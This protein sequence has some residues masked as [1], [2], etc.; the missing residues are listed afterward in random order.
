MTLFVEQII[1][2]NLLNFILKGIFLKIHDF[3]FVLY[4]E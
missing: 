4:F 2:S 3:S 1:L